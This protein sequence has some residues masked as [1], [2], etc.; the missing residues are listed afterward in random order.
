MKQSSR[1]VRTW[2]FLVLVA[3][4]TLC[5]GFG[6]P[7]LAARDCGAASLWPQQ[8]R[9]LAMLGRAPQEQARAALLLDVSTGRVLYEKNAGERVA[10]ASTTKMMTALLAL[11]RGNLTDMVTVEADDLAVTSAAGLWAGQTLTLE[12]MLHA[13]LLPSDNAAAVAIAR[14]VGGS[15]AAFVAMM[16][17]RAAEWGL[18]DTHFVNPHG[19]DDPAHYSSARDLA[20][21]ALRGLT[22]PTFARIVSTRE[23]V[24]GGRTL[25]NLNELL[26]SYPGA[27]GVKTGTTDEAGQCLISAAG[28]ADGRVLA[29]VMGSDDRFRDSRALLDYYF[30]SYCLVPLRLGPKGINLLPLGDGST[31]VLALAGQPSALLPRWQ[32]PW[33]QVVRVPGERGATGMARFLVG[34]TVVAEEP[35]MVLAP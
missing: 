23:R 32:L 11:E 14:H 34:G 25:V 12:D 26:G 5:L 30:A 13:L 22:E 19:L 28:R 17:A 21:I 4:Q 35:L 31:A 7:R 1:Q 8:V 15:E 3:G 6:P 33:L 16:N 27:E 24:V 29:V 2:L 10:P 18:A 9:Q 20:Q